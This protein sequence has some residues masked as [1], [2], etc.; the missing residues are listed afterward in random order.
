MFIAFRCKGACYEHRTLW[1]PSCS[2][3]P[4]VLSLAVHQ[5]KQIRRRLEQH[6]S[7]PFLHGAVLLPERR[8]TVLFKRSALSGQTG[9][10]DYRQS[11]GGA[12]G[13]ESERFTAWIYR[14]GCGWHWDLIR[15]GWFFLCYLQLPWKPGTDGHSAAYAACRSRPQSG[16]LRNRL[17]G[18]A[19]GAADLAGTLHNALFAGGRN[20]T[21]WQPG[22]CRDQAISGQQLPG[23]HLTWP[24]GRD[25][26]HQ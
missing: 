9:W 12:H 15:Q 5:Q 8:R 13:I 18:L 25:R 16:W 17:S 4:W 26:T 20:A 1:Y 7:H 21:V 23:G 6:G 24:S 3:S 2:R 11:T 14:S 10:Y 19:G 22:V